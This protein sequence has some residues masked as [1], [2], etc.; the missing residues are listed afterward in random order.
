[1]TKAFFMVKI[2]ITLKLTRIK[3]IQVLFITKYWLNDK[4]SR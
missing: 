3:N 1:L 2:I 4:I